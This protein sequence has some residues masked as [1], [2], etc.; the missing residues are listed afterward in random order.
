MATTWTTE[1]NGVNGWVTQGGTNI[2]TV[3]VNNNFGDNEALTFGA[4]SDYGIKFDS[5]DNALDFLNPNN[6]TI[7]KLG[8]TGLYLEQVNFIE[9][10]TLPSPVKGRMVMHNNEYYLGVD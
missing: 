9:L 7:A 6:Q 8:L 4:D 10:S 2:Q 1:G 5:S 3:T